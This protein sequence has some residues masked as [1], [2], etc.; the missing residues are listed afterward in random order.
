MHGKEKDVLSFCNLRQITV[1]Q[2]TTS[3]CVD[4]L[5]PECQQQVE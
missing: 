3:L 4:F 5:N 1:V 2:E